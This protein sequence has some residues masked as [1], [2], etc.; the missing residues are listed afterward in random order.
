MY[1]MDS[2]GFSILSVIRDNY[3]RDIGTMDKDGYFHTYIEYKEYN[4]NVEEIKILADI[5]YKYP[6]RVKGESIS[7]FASKP[8][9]NK[10]KYLWVILSKEYLSILQKE[11]CEIAEKIK[12]EGITEA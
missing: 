10:K 5:Y 8:V 3:R 1:N 11:R 7:V 2:E 9:I 6:V 12:K 4:V